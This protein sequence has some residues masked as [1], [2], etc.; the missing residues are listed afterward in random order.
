MVKARTRYWS[1]LLT[2]LL[3]VGLVAG[4]TAPSAAQ[5]P[6][7]PLAGRYTI[8]GGGSALPTVK[9]LS[10]AFSKQH[11]SVTF[12]LEDV[13]SDGGVALTAQGG[14]DLGMISRDLKP[15]EQGLVETLLIG[16]LG[17]GVVVHP[18]NSV[19]AVSRAQLRDIFSGVVTDWSQVGGQPGRI[20]IFVREPESATRSSFESYVFEGRAAYPSDAVQFDEL[21]GMLNG[22][23]G[24]KNG[25]GMATIND[26]TLADPSIRFLAIDGVSPS[27]ESLRTGTYAIRRPLHITFRSTDVKPAAQAF[28]EF[29]RSPEGQALTIN[30]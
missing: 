29:V 18:E 12:S 3:Y 21:E 23:R 16:V 1:A 17:T 8:K 20:S 14:A 15:A 7:D 4:C 24:L 27:R 6:V 2:L 28:L 25:I 13:G 22:L 5:Q 9:S 11:P 30:L 19:R 26:T 10:D